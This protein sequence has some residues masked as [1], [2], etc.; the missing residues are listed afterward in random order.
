M[1]K[2]LPPGHRDPTDRVTSECDRCGQSDDHPK[3]HSF[4][5]TSM[6][7]DCRNSPETVALLDAAG[8]RRGLELADYLQKG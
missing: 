7:L 1:V 2:N 3:D 6:H 8:E 5:G 4:D